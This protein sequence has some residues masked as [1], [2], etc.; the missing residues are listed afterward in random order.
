MKVNSC[1]TAACILRV[2][3]QTNRNESCAR[4]TRDQRLV[5]A[6][7]LTT[8]P[9]QHTRSQP[10]NR[11]HRDIRGHQHRA[12]SCTLE[13]RHAPRARDARKC[14]RA[15]PF[16]R[17]AARE[18]VH[19]AVHVCR[20]VE[21][22]EVVCEEAARHKQVHESVRSEGREVEAPR[23]SSFR[24]AGPASRAGERAREWWAGRTHHTTYG[25]VAEPT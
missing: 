25:A 11:C 5:A 10:Q 12:H 21:R 7:V 9:A 6:A 16:L 24:V 19:V 20:L 17:S 23:K 18:E 3:W 2:R 8:I 4:T 15:A 13:A 1:T 22:L 14:I